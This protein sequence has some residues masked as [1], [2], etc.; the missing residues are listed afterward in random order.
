MAASNTRECF[1]EVVGKKVIGVIFN[2]AD[3]EREP[4]ITLVFEDGT[5]LCFSGTFWRENAETV[6]LETS[7][8]QKELELL[9]DELSEVLK[10]AGVLSERANAR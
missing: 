9:R 4:R 3:P 10:L 7:K 1:T 8:K 2:R 5:G 6:A